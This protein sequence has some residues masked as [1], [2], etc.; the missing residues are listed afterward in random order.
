MLTRH[1]RV[2]HRALYDEMLGEKVAKRIKTETSSKSLGSSK[3]QSSIESFVEYT[4]S[5]DRTIMSW[6]VQTYQPLTACERP[7]FRE[8]RQSLNPK[9]PTIGVY[10]VKS[11]LSTECA[12]LKI[13]LRT[14]L[15]GAAISVTTDAWISCK[16]VTFITCTAHFIHPQTWLLH[17][18]P[19]GTFR[20]LAHHLQRMW[21]A[22]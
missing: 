17:H 16:N 18:M 15:E 20:N 21:C 2:K 5:F 13:K 6:I 8:M 12:C 14:I 19:W 9:S 1:V 7:S 10:K 11:L 4:H 3:V 22:M